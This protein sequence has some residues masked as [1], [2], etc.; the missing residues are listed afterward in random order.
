M[1]PQQKAERREALQ[2]A[3]LVVLDANHTQFGLNLHGITMWTSR[4]GFSNLTAAEVEPEL[5]YL[6]ERGLIAEV[7]K[8]LEPANRYWKR[9]GLGRDYLSERGK[10]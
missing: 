4:Q 2:E 6:K 9:T 7:G 5:E 8:T 3:I 1:T 10:A